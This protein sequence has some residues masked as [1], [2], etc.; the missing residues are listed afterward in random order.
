ME[1]LGNTQPSPGFNTPT[2]QNKPIKKLA[3]SPFSKT[4]S[5]S[6]LL[7]VRKG[8]VPFFHDKGAFLCWNNGR[9]FVRREVGLVPEAVA[10][11]KLRKEI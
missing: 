9:F 11:A 7:A 10:A 1:L 8:P 6:V 2:C 3:L 5:L 4:I